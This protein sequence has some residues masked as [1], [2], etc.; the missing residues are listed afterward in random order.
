MD[1]R[2]IVEIPELPAVDHFPPG[3]V[4]SVLFA[5]LGETPEACRSDRSLMKVFT[6]LNHVTDKAVREYSAARDSVRE[7]ASIEIF[8]AITLEIVGN[9]GQ[10]LRLATDHLETCLDATHRGMCAV[11]LFRERGFGASAPRADQ[12]AVDRLKYIRDT[13]QHAPDRLLEDPEQLRRGRLPIG[14]EDPYGIRL[15]EYEL[16]IGTDQPLTYVELVSLMENCYR[17]AQVI[18]GR[19]VLS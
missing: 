4:H 18:G 8:D 17:T 6:L 19:T 10:Q 12:G 2:E 5:M 7:L 11:A 14:P 1:I 13:V 3:V 16:T 9:A 15:R